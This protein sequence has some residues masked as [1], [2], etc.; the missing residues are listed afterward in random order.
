[1]LAGAVAPSFAH[2]HYVGGCGSRAYPTSARGAHGAPID[3]GDSIAMSLHWAMPEAEC[4]SGPFG[5]GQQPSPARL[6][7]LLSSLSLPG[8]SYAPSSRLVLALACGEDGVPCEVLVT[9]SSGAFE[10]HGVWN[11]E[12]ALS[13]RGTKCDGRRIVVSRSDVSTHLLLWRAPPRGPYTERSLLR[14]AVKL[15]Q[16]RVLGVA[17]RRYD[18]RLPRRRKAR[19]SREAC[20]APPDSKRTACRRSARAGRWADA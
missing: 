12:P 1:M 3:G 14:R 10:E 15:A 17:R 19:A 2:P 18:W 9:A 6:A 7:A 16:R 11:S 8:A 5:I 13:S 4:A 20:A